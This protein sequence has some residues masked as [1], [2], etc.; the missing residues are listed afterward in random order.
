[1]IVKQFSRFLVVGTLG[2]LI[3]AAILFLFNGILGLGPLL[4]RIPSFSVAVLATWWMNRRYTFAAK[5][6]SAKQT[7]PAYI[8]SNMVGLGFNLSVYSVAVLQIPLLHAYP[9]LALAA[10]SVAG[11]FFNFT[12]SKFFVFRKRPDA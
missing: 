1:M 5:D 12:A 3:E 10:G 9:I 4:A 11:L 6:M 2:F 8:S 7:L